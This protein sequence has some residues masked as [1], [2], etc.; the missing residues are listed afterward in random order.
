M[1]DVDPVDLGPPQSVSD[2]VQ[3]VA[4]HPVDSLYSG[5]SER[6]G[7][8]VGDG[9]GHEAELAPEAPPAATSNVARPTYSRA[10]SRV[11]RT[12]YASTMGRC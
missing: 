2:A 1:T 5:D 9:R 11:T 12:G 6:G 8:L 10:A 3:A 4:H 7:E